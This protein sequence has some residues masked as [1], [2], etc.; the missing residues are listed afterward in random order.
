MFSK[1][2]IRTMYN[3]RGLLKFCQ[4]SLRS[5]GS[6]SSSSSAQKMRQIREDFPL[7]VNEERQTTSLASHDSGGAAARGKGKTKT[8]SCFSAA[9]RPFGL[10]HKKMESQT[11]KTW[12]KA[13]F[14]PSGQEEETRSSSLYFLFF[15]FYGGVS[16]SFES[17]WRLHSTVTPFLR[18]C[19]GR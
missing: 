6:I 5:S 3:R 11:R 10:S 12:E 2:E 14:S 8:T 15:F 9:V 7:I 1:P 16:A 13:I 4:A 18:L 19:S 17:V